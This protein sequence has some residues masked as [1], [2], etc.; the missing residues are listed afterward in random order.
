MRPNR[1]SVSELF[2]IRSSRFSILAVQSVSNTQE[3]QPLRYLRVPLQEPL[4][5]DKRLTLGR[6][7]IGDGLA[8]ALSTMR[9]YKTFSTMLYAVNVLTVF[10]GL[11]VF[12]MVTMQTDTTAMKYLNIIFLIGAPFSLLHILS[13]LLRL[14]TEVVQKCLHSFDVIYLLTMQLF[15]AIFMCYIYRKYPVVLIFGILATAASANITLT[16]AMS[17]KS[18]IRAGSSLM[19][20]F[21]LMNIFMM[22]VW[23]LSPESPLHES[24][25]LPGTFWLTGVGYHP[26]EI[27]MMDFCAERVITQMIFFL[28]FFYQQW[29][30]PSAAI[31]IYTP[32]VRA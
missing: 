27:N 15:F 8:D 28:R 20:F 29:K 9:S 13:S 5:I 25:E 3:D 19:I 21:I 23:K 18:R 22:I 31:N 7:L 16:D 2:R 10:V 17:E 4:V 24:I 30:Y 6:S 32:Y 26:I 14:I 12:A 11:V 1:A